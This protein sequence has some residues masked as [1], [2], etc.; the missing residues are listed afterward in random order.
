M[1]T[2]MIKKFAAETGKSVRA[3][4]ALW[5]RAKKIADKKF[6]QKDA[7][8]YAY[9]T[10]ILKNMIGLSAV[11]PTVY[12]VGGHVVICKG[13]KKLKL[14]GA[15]NARRARKTIVGKTWWDKLGREQKTEYLK[16]HPNSAFAKL[17]R[18]EME[19]EDKKKDSE[20]ELKHKE[21]VPEKDE[22]EQEEPEL[23][24]EPGEPE[25]LAAVTP[26][27]K[28]KVFSAV[29]KGLTRLT[30]IAPEKQQTMK[31]GL[32]ALKRLKEGHAISKEGKQHLQDLCNIVMGVTLAS[33]ICLLPTVP[34][35]MRL[36]AMYFEHLTNVRRDRKEAER[37]RKRQEKDE[38]E[39]QKAMEEQQKAVE[40]PAVVEEADV[41][42]MTS[43]EV[44]TL[45]HMSLDMTGWLA[46][47]H[48]NL[49][50]EA[51][52]KQ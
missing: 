35:A 46:A 14:S 28:G 20:D 22:E 25:S 37:D 26:E 3:V 7:H 23:K 11:D 6:K 17:K 32:D 31:H 45:Q 44:N 8:Y 2:P 52:S 30:H 10:S 42:T 24:R 21:H 43:D 34:Y 5:N 41:N 19:K 18:A 38:A 47:D 40:E 4:E 50:N 12:N 49:L 36:S 27:N 16:S 51:R 48:E 15:I 29:T 13:G 33:A 39:Q 9:T 1:P